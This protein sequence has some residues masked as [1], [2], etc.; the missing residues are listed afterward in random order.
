MTPKMMKLT[1]REFIAERRDQWP[2]GEYLCAELA[3]PHE[4]ACGPLWLALPCGPN[5]ACE[6]PQ[7]PEGLSM[8]A[9]AGACF[10]PG[11]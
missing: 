10:S 9:C 8:A 4:Q 3:G 11:S 2:A 5:L 1:N 7:A 6:L